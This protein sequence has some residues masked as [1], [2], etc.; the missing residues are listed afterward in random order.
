MGIG[1]FYVNEYRIGI[2]LGRS[3]SVEM[4]VRSGERVGKDLVEGEFGVFWW[5]KKD[6]EGLINDF[7][8]DFAVSVK[9][10]YPVAPG[11]F[12]GFSSVFSTPTLQK[13]GI[14]WCWFP[15]AII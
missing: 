9:I 4:W 12:K 7:N 14:F 11:I 1:D 6:Y 13:I 15:G 8:L 10:N 5:G 3:D 2:Y